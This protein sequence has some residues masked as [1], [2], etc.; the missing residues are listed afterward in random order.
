MALNLPA[1]HRQGTP[2]CEAQT[3]W[4]YLDDGRRE[5]AYCHQWRGLRQVDG[6]RYCPAPGHRE[7]VIAQARRAG[8]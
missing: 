4:R 7:R 8:E 5:P 6:H 3:S 1:R 2:R